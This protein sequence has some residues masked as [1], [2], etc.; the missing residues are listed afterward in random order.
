MIH[1][2][3]QYFAIRSYVKRLSQELVRR[4]GR[5]PFYPIEQVTLAAQRG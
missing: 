3:K 2:L 5:K 1:H 4:F